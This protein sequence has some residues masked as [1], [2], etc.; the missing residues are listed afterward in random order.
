[1]SVKRRRYGR[2]GHGYQVD[3]AKTPGVTTV[4]SATMPKGGLTDWAARCGADH[5]IDYWDELAALKPSER[6]KRVHYAYRD[7]RDA[8]AKRGTEVHRLASRLAQGEE[9]TVPDELAGHVEAYRDWLDSTD[10]ATVAVELV[11]ASRQHRY[12]G[13]S[14]LIG[15]LGEV[16][17]DDQGV[18]PPGRWLLELKTTRTGVWPESAIQATAYRNAE[19][20]VHPD[21]PD[22][23]MLTEWLGIQHCGVV[24]IRSDTCELHPV[25]SGPEVWDT[26]LRLRWLYDHQDAMPGWI[27]PAASAAVLATAGPP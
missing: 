11:M 19:I 2:T 21:K 25:E 6:H 26:W 14:D 1:M 22:E 27:G 10:L 17:T 12:C 4:L 5:L 8:A 24:W 3:G 15:D 18:I 20:Y 16:L 7:E 9:V 23:E 13:T